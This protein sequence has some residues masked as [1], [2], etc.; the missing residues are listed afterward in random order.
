[1]KRIA[2][3]LVGAVALLLELS[4]AH[5]AALEGW[6]ATRSLFGSDPGTGRWVSHGRSPPVAFSQFSVVAHP[7]VLEQWSATRSMLGAA[8]SATAEVLYDQSSLVRG[9]V[10]DTVALDAPAAGEISLTLTD[11]DFTQSLALGFSLTDSPTALVALADPGTL[12]LDVSGPTTLYAKVFATAQGPA[13][14][15]LFNLTATYLSTPTVVGLPASG[16]LLGASLCTL[17]VALRA[18][19]RKGHWEGTALG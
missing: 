7:S 14:I 5:A 12:T 16:L 1:M 15:G 4:S 19:F 2:I 6:S 8:P 17:L 10:A 3:G 11:L 9:N 13:D 18:R